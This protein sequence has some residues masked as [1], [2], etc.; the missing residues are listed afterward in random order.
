MWLFRALLEF[1]FPFRERTTL[2]EGATAR[3][4]FSRCSPATFSLD[5]V[6]GVG[7]L[8]YRDA[9]VRACIL[10]AK[11]HANAHAQQLLGEVLTDFVLERVTD[12]TAFGTKVML[13]PLPLGEKRRKERGY[14][15]VEEIC[16]HTLGRLEGMA[17]LAPEALTRVR[18]TLPQTEL[19]GDARRQN[20]CEAF[21]AAPNLNPS[22]TYIIVDDV[23]TT[24]ATLLAAIEALHDA[25]LPT[26]SAIALAH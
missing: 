21:R 3:D 7:L 8:P 17:M 2:V 16:R 15:Q 18:E 22:H 13:V 26:V 10:E 6:E 4:L 1:L 12:A 9:L 25:G 14:N 20:M 11:F 24:G 19:P 5:G 23:M